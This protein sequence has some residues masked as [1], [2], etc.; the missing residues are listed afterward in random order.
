MKA[1]KT[2]CHRYFAV[3]WPDSIQY[4]SMIE[5]PDLTRRIL[6]YF[7]RED[8]TFPANATIETLL[9]EFPDAD[10]ATLSYHI[11]CC[12][13][14]DLLFGQ[15]KVIEGNSGT[16]IFTGWLSGL[17]PKGGEYVRDSRS[18]YWKQAWKKIEDAGMTVTTDKLIECM[19]SIIKGVLS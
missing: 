5:N 11:L 9:V 14:N 15:A 2:R 8:V 7:A 3:L 10:R 4:L 19:S 1:E 18:V 12:V 16:E 6:E 13:K 17:T